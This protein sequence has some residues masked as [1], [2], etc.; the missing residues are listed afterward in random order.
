MDPKALAFLAAGIGAAGVTFG[1]A[2]GIS[3]LASA[4]ISGTSSRTKVTPMKM[5]N[6]FRGS[7]R[8]G[9][10]VSDCASGSVGVAVQRK[11]IG[12]RVR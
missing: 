5:T 11:G 8:C 4:A 10:S 9:Q 2:F 7:E 3:K 6:P 12:R 1:A